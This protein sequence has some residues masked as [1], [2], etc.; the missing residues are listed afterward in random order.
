[1]AVNKPEI[2]I[3][4]EARQMIANGINYTIQQT[5]IAMYRLEPII[6]AVYTEVKA[7]ADQ[8]LAQIQAQYEQEVQAEAQKSSEEEAKS[9]N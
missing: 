1:M 2:I 7:Q 9:E 6:K 4:N 3:E 8:E 5:G